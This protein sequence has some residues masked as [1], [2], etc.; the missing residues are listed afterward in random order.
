M[1]EHCNGNYNAFARATHINVAILYRVLNNKANAG[2]KTIN[3]LIDYLK[4]NSLV[5]ENYIFLP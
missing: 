3:K 5:I 2:L 1:N 4:A